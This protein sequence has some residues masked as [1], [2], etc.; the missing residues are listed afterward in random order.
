MTTYAI[1][2]LHGRHDLLMGALHAI[3]DR[4]F[5]A[6]KPGGTIVTLGDYIDRGPKSAQIVETLMAGLD[7][8]FGHDHGF[9]LVCLRGNHEDIM[10][11]SHDTKGLTTR[12]WTP[13]GGG[14]TLLS[15]GA[16][17]GDTLGSAWDRVP[18]AHIDWLRG[19]PRLHVDEH[20]VFVHA[21]VI[22]GLPLEQQDDEKMGWMLYPEGA[23]GGHEGRHVV[24]GHH[25]FA[26]GPK[27]FAAR[28][29]LDTLAWLTGRLV[30]GVFDDETAGGAVDFI[31]VIDRP[32]DELWEAA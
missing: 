31:E 13:N 28:T 5:D 11:A 3:R 29:D 15:Y 22:D 27:V 18:A 6:G 24:H 8:I 23:D 25:Q 7:P 26:D 1:A 4:D 19:L 10:L 21:G 2:D 12:W 32:Y 16:R 30:V 17:E 14:A 20:R 9:K